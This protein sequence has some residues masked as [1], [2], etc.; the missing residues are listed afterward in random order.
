[1]NEMKIVKETAA[2]E[3][4]NWKNSFRKQQ[5]A[6]LMEKETAIRRQCKKERDREI[7]IVIEKLEN[8][9]NKARSQI[10]QTTENRIK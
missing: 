10:E 7:E 3:M 9:A 2:I 6:L 5:S 8:E 4:E 1:M